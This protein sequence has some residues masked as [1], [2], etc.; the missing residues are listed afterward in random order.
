MI[1]SPE[2]WALEQLQKHQE[3][4]GIEFSNPDAEVGGFRKGPDGSLIP[5]E[6]PDKD[7]D[8]GKVME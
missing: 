2:D 4:Q 5:Y 6:A 8:L 3:E 1:Q 7:E